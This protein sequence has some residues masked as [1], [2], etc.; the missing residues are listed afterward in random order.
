MRVCIYEG[1]MV[2]SLGKFEKCGARGKAGLT[3]RYRKSLQLQKTWETKCCWDW[4]GAV[5]AVSLA[6]DKFGP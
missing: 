3:P 2:L 1:W 6:A 4:L 5:N